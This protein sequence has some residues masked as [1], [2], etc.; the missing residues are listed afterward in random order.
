MSALRDYACLCVLA[1]RACLGMNAILMGATSEPSMPVERKGS[2]SGAPPIRVA[3]VEDD[4]WI[5]DNLARQID[6]APGYCCISRYRTGE[7]ALAGLP[8]EAPDV[9]LMDIN[10]P[11]LSGIEC[12][13]RLKALQPSV[14]VLMLTV[15]EESDSIFDSLRAG[16]SGYLLKRSAEKELLEAIAQVHQG[17]SPM[18]SLVARKVVQF[19]N[20]IGDATPEL[21][22]L[23]PREKEILELLSR[24][25]AYKEIGDRLSLSIHTVRMHIRGI[26]GK[27]QVHSR[28]EAVSKYLRS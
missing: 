24:G 14:A 19:F 20:R 16:A 7:E 8:G 6:V 1:P 26:Y 23:S 9:V 27:L 11:G 10:L 2:I 28:G 12:V 18:S 22:R 15:Y 13:R 25:A 4:D 21:Q 3:I 17:G 5:R